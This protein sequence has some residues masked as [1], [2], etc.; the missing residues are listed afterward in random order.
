LKVES[1]IFAGTYGGGVYKSS[2][3]GNSW[4]Q[5]NNGLFNSYVYALSHDQSSIYAATASGL[6]K[7]T[8]MGGNWLDVTISIGSPTFDAV[9]FDGTY[10]IAGGFS[11]GL[12]RSAD[13]GATWVSANTGLSTMDIRALYTIGETIFLGCAKGSFYSIDHGAT[14]VEYNLGFSNS[15]YIQSYGIIGSTLLCGTYSNGIWKRE[16][17]NTLKI[18]ESLESSIS[19]YP[20]PTNGEFSISL[21]TINEEITITNIL[22]TEIFKTKTT[23]N[24]TIFQLNF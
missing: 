13:G 18:P 8:N 11:C 7:S 5:S 19:I 20:N 3:S 2:D 21:P 16:L 10:I 17:T 14:W 9:T 6:F 4:S 1:N 23:E 22:G 15:Y 24:R 12:Y